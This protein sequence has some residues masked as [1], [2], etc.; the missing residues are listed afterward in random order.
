MLERTSSPTP[1]TSPTELMDDT[2]TWEIVENAKPDPSPA[3]RIEALTAQ[4]A[5]LKAAN[6]LLTQRLH[7]TSIAAARTATQKNMLEAEL[8]TE[9]NRNRNKTLETLTTLQQEKF[10]LETQLTQLKE[11]QADHKILKQDHETLKKESNHL[12]KQLSEQHEQNRKSLENY[13]QLLKEKRDLTNQLAESQQ[14]VH[15]LTNENSRLG[16]L[17]NKDNMFELKQVNIAALS[18][19]LPPK[20][21]Y[22]SIAAQI[23]PE[24]AKKMTAVSAKN[25]ARLFATQRQ[26]ISTLQHTL[27]ERVDSPTQASKQ[28]H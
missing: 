18:A 15:Q 4:Y 7:K 9:R 2:T 12:H 26:P 23:T 24:D 21:S 10:V 16:T 27:A 11:L 19:P 14:K 5:E 1:P 13:N 3:E 28:R 25:P 8:E 6:T 22:A 17:V 20:R